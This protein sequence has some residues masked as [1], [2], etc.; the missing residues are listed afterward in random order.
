[1]PPDCAV[2][3]IPNVM[4]SSVW[5]LSCRD[6]RDRP[7]LEHPFGRHSRTQTDRLA[8]EIMRTVADPASRRDAYLA[9]DVKKRID[10]GRYHEIHAEQMVEMERGCDVQVA[11]HVLTTFRKRR[12]FYAAHHPTPALM[13]Y[14]VA[15]IIGHPRFAPFRR[16][17]VAA[18]LSEAARFLDAHAPFQGEEVPIHPQVARFFGLEWWTPTMTYQIDRLEVTF[19]EWLDHYMADPLPEPA[20]GITG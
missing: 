5:P 7:D 16:A 6:P 2:I 11:A 1:M 8:L 14:L 13:L 3:R 9:V 17:S 19:E 18:L 15:Q 4:F 10:L 20:R 12:L